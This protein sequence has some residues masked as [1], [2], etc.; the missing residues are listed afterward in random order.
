MSRI[1]SPEQSNLLTEP[2]PRPL[3]RKSRG[4]PPVGRQEDRRQIELFPDLPHLEEPVPADH[5][6]RKPGAA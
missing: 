2:K 3:K 6:Q 5:D 1:Q 4:V